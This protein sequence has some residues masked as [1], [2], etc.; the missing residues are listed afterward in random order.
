MARDERTG[1]YA[2]NVSQEDW[3]L[4]HKMSKR[5]GFGFGVKQIDEAIFVIEKHRLVKQSI[6]SNVFFLQLAYPKT[7]PPANQ[8][9]IKKF[10]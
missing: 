9:A 8:Y 2:R 10:K 5:D 6:Y 1:A 7:L 4:A 3:D